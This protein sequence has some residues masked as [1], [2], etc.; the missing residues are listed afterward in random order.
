MLLIHSF[1]HESVTDIHPHPLSRQPLWPRYGSRRNLLHP[2][3]LHPRHHDQQEEIWKQEIHKGLVSQK[4]HV[5]PIDVCVVYHFLPPRAYH[6]GHTICSMPW[7]IIDAWEL[8]VGKVEIMQ[9]LFWRA[10]SWSS[11]DYVNCYI[12]LKSLTCF[13]SQVLHLKFFWK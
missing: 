11:H 7:L 9:R 8:L 6:C 13:H 2:G 10:G 12:A 3:D 5:D 4:T 1:I